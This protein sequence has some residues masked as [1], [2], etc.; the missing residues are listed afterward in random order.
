MLGRTAAS[1]LNRAQT[2]SLAW[3]AVSGK[4]SIELHVLIPWFIVVKST[5]HSLCTSLGTW[6]DGLSHV[7]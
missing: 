5:I 7:G 2:L 4:T 3:S 6:G 1:N